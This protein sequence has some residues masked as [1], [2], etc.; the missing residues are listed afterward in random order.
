[1][2]STSA[3]PVGAVGP[4]GGQE[5]YVVVGRRVGDTKT[6][7]HPFEEGRVGGPRFRLPGEVFADLEDDLVQPAAQLVFGEQRRV[8]PPVG[9]RV[10][11]LEEAALVACG[12]EAEELHPHAGGGAATRGVED[13]GR[14]AAGHHALSTVPSIKPYGSLVAWKISPAFSIPKRSRS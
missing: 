7:R 13:M 12:A 10:R 6:D 4:G 14:Q 11:L 9:V 3:S 8:G 1:M 5:R 2:S